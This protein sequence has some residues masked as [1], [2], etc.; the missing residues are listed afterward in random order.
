MAFVT[1]N[2]VFF[3]EF[4]EL[5]PRG[6]GAI[7][8]ETALTEWAEGADNIPVMLAAGLLAVGSHEAVA[9]FRPRVAEFVIL[10]PGVEEIVIV[11]RAELVFP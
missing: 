5:V 2:V 3:A 11:N 1:G 10:F 7:R 9:L 4:F 8:H 6:A